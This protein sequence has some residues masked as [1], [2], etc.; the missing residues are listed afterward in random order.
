MVKRLVEEAKV[1][2]VIVF[3]HDLVF[4]CQLTGEAR[5]QKVDVLC[6]QIESLSSVG[7]ISDS[8]PW[9]AMPVGQRT[10]TLQEL[11]KKAQRADSDG[12]PE[13]YRSAVYVLFTA[14]CYLGTEY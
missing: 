11:M 5:L 2:Q 8:E 10:T 9:D 7:L 1:R 12:K 3:T 4:Y 13:E 14:A 6:Q